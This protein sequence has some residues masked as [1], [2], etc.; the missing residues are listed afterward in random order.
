ML[1]YLGE[2][3]SVGVVHCVDRLRGSPDCVTELG[4]QQSLLLVKP[5]R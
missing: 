2:Y 5:V 4:L 1:G 3:L